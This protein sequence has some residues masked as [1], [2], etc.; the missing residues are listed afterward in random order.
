MSSAK[1]TQCAAI[2]EIAKKD[3]VVELLITP[4]TTCQ[5]PLSALDINL[6]YRDAIPAER[7]TV[8]DVLGIKYVQVVSSGITYFIYV[9]ALRDVVHNLKLFT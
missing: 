9:G 8:Y 5:V 3:G 2:N 1:Y 6:Y 7:K 4:E